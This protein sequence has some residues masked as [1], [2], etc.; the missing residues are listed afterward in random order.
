M[1]N[2]SQ[3]KQPSS[4]QIA[5]RMPSTLLERIDAFAEQLKLRSPGLRITR[6]DA[7]RVMI[8]NA[9]AQSELSNPSSK[10]E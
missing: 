10:Q 6:A 8:E 3:I 7:I 9:L 5:I 1:V 4:Q 2:K